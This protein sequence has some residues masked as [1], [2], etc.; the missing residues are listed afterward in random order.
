MKMINEQMGEVS[1]A[2]CAK[3]PK[4]TA[5]V[6]KLPQEVLQ[7]A[8]E[9]VRACQKPLALYPREHVLFDADVVVGVRSMGKLVF[10]DP[11][12]RWVL[13]I[14]KKGQWIARFSCQKADLARYVGRYVEVNV[15]SDVYLLGNIDRQGVARG[16]IHTLDLHSIALHIGPKLKQDEQSAGHRQA[17]QTEQD[18]MEA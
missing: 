6:P 14:E 11:N 1:E 16:E 4:K 3:L 9:A 2:V 10:N 7:A 13:N 8:Q 15:G 12:G 17:R 5:G 18:L